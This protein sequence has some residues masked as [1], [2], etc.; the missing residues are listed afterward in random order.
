[1]D[2]SPGDSTPTSEA[3]Y[4]H[5][6][7]PTTGSILAN[8][9]QPT[10]SLNCDNVSN[11]PVLLA[12]VLPRLIMHS[13]ASSIG[14]VAS[15]STHTLHFS[16]PS[17]LGSNNSSINANANSNMML[18]GTSAT[19]AN[20]TAINSKLHTSDPKSTANMSPHHLQQQQAHI[21]AHHL[22]NHHHHHQM[23]HMQSSANNIG[24]QNSVTNVSGPNHDMNSN[25]AGK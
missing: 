22:L 4:S 6:S 13:P 23:H 25:V 20:S 19:S 3:S 21:H 16:T 11:G 14:G 24:A 2:I 5:S 9:G 15:T 10:N 7:T 1:M 8:S 18:G 12:N 17:T